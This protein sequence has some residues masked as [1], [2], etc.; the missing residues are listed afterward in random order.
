M[1]ENNEVIEEVIEEVAVE[2]VKSPG[3]VKRNWE[4]HGG[5]VKKAAKSVA[6][7]LAM[8]LAYGLGKTS[9]TSDTEYL[10]YSGEDTDSATDYDYDV[11]ATVEDGSN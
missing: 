2:E 1:T 10:G 3:F 11:D 9:N 7:V 5:K 6:V 8:G 4:R